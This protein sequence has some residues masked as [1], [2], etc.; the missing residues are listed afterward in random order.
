VSGPRCGSADE[1]DGG[2]QRR[3]LVSAELAFVNAPGA[4]AADRRGHRH[5]DAVDPV[6]AVEHDRRGPELAVSVEGGDRA[7]EA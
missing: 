2:T 4:D 5:G 6:L 3:E 7:R 1:L